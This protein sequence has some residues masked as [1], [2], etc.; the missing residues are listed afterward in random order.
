MIKQIAGNND[1]PLLDYYNNPL[2][3]GKFGLFNAD[4]H[5]NIKGAEVFSEL[6]SKD[7]NQILGKK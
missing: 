2:F 3:L 5:L 4:T 7:L 6:F 1:I